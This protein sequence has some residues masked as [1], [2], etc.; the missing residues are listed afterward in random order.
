[1][2][3]A[4]HIFIMSLSVLIMLTVTFIPH[5]H[6][7]GVE[8]MFM[9]QCTYHDHHASHQSDC[10]TLA[11]HICIASQF[12]SFRAETVSHHTKNT[13]QYIFSAALIG[14]NATTVCTNTASTPWAYGFSYHSSL[15]KGVHSL[16]APPVAFSYL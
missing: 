12:L 10:N 6:H 16:R 2:K 8:C 9:V 5:H 13:N 3:R 1:M 15:C 4:A 14:Y 11:S 7:S